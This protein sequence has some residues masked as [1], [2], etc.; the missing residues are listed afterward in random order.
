MSVALLSRLVKSR[1]LVYL[2]PLSEEGK[3]IRRAAFRT[4]INGTSSWQSVDPSLVVLI[5][6]LRWSWEVNGGIVPHDATAHCMSIREA[7]RC[8]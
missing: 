4:N 8:P 5:H 6:Q 2:S 7:I 1:K 3:H